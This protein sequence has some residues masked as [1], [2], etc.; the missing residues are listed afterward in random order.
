MAFQ[1]L[2]RFNSGQIT[3]QRIDDPAELEIFLRLAAKGGW[4]PA[5]RLPSRSP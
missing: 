3:E 5:S 2:L 4:A 1:A